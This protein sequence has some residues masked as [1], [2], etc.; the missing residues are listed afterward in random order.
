MMKSV[1]K[2]NI[3]IGATVLVSL[4]L[5]YW[6]IEFLKG[7]NIFSSNTTFYARFA[8]V[9]DLAVSSPVNVNGY[10]VG[11]IR[12]I[13][14]DYDNNQIVVE[15][16]F[17]KNLKVPKGS[18]ISLATS[19]LGTSVLNLNLS[20]AKSYYEPGSTIPTLPVGGG[21]MD[22]VSSKVMPSVEVM[23]PK[24][25]S[26]LGSVNTLMANP[27]LYASVTRL[28][29]ITAELNRSSIELAQLLAVVNS[30]MPQLLDNVNGVVVNANG[31]VTNAGALAKDL[32]KTSGNLNELS[33]SLKNMPLDTTLAR[34]NRTLANVQRLSAQLNDPNSSIGMLMHDRQL[35]QNASGAVAS[36]QALLE[37]IKKNPKKYV[38]IK[39][40]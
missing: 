31:A 24:V 37:D 17:D 23:L 2:R 20:D 10:T 19:L 21:L 13:N 33:Q 1:S 32:Q 26:I 16:S 18:T 7:S 11:Q 40:F 6:G 28:D 22:Q 35:Y 12:S 36:L 25:D 39:V 15:M 27:A 8:K 3:Y 38:T 34:V 30:R 9:E 29:Q 4:F 14:Y 5:L